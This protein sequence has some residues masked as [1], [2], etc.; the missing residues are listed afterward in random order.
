M[1]GKYICNSQFANCKFKSG[2]LNNRNP[3]LLEPLAFQTVLTTLSVNSPLVEP[4]RDARMPLVFRTNVQQLPIRQLLMGSVPNSNRS[5][6]FHR[7]TCK[8]L[9]PTNPFIISLHQ[10]HYFNYANNTAESTETESD[11]N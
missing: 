8:P 10:A 2:E 9:T 6:M 7:H 4:I 3:F 11:T 1:L 5:L